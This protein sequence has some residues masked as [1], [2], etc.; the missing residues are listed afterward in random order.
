MSFLIEIAF[1]KLFQSKPVFL[2]GR[3]AV[4]LPRPSLSR[5]PRAASVKTWRASANRAAAWS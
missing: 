1:A 3:S 2:F 4:F 5:T